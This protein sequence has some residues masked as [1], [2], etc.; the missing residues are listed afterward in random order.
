V[1]TPAAPAG[2]AGDTRRVYAIVGGQLISEAGSQMTGFL[3]PSIAVLVLG[4]SPLVIGVFGIAQFISAPVFGLVA[5]VY[6][7]RWPRRRLLVA[8]DLIRATA[9]ATLALAAGAGRLTVAHIVVVLLVIGAFT[10]LFDITG[11]SVIPRLTANLT[12]ANSLFTFATSVGLFV[13]PAV[14]GWLLQGPGGATGLWIDAVTY[15]ASIAGV[16]YALHSLSD[17]PA[18]RAIGVG[19]T[20]PAPRLRDAIT[21]VW[22]DPV[23]RRLSSVGFWSNLGLQTVQASYLV[24]AYRSLHLSAGQVGAIF[25][26]GA[27]FGAVTAVLAGRFLDRVPN[28]LT[29]PVSVGVGGTAWL[30]LL[31]P[32]GAAFAKATVACMLVSAF[33]PLYNIVQ[34]T[35]RQQLAAPGTEGRVNAGV[36]TISWLSIPLGY[37]LGGAIGDLVNPRAAI[38]VGSCIAIAGVAAALRIPDVGPVAVDRVP[39]AAGPPTLAVPADGVLT[40][41]PERDSR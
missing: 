32:G 33:L 40:D 16:L 19:S 6:A 7:D 36:R 8:S 11:Q 17:R 9:L 39:P 21:L 28:R 30:L 27:V 31:L 14:A 24:F 13:G 25:S 20:P 15:L 35:M 22:S 12:R 37:L 2:T 34:L 18:T 29:L 23:L 10:V 26:I 41:A 3:I 5:G 1:S 38:L 4:V